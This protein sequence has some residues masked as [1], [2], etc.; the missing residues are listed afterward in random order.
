ME[1]I[2]LR[3]SSNAAPDYVKKVAGA[4]GWQLRENGM[5]KV[6]AVKT[7]AVNIATKAIAICNQR[8][9]QAGV[10]L[11]VEPVFGK[12][13]D[14][15]DKSVTALEMVVQETIYPCPD[16]FLEYRVSGRKCDNKI[17]PKLAEALAAPVRDGKGVEM[18]CIGPSAVYRAMLA[19]TIARGLLFPNGMDAVIVPVWDSIPREN[20]PPLSMIKIRFWGK[21]KC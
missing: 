10:V 17:S 20:A 3:I 6:R 8:V 1:E 9:S 7:Q 16:K 11:C 15:D 14:A 12:A 13:D 19:S 2:I 21:S 4:M 18:K 5:F